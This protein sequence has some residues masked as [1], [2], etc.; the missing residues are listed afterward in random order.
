MHAFLI[1][2]LVVV[3][4]LGGVMWLIGKAMNDGFFPK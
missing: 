3:V 1:G 4:L 2:G